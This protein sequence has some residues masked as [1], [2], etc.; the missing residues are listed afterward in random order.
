MPCNCPTL[1]G[2]IFSRWENSPIELPIQRSNDSARALHDARIAMMT[3]TTTIR[4]R[5]ARRSFSHVLALTLM[6]AMTLAAA[7]SA[8]AAVSDGAC[9]YLYEYE[10]DDGAS[11][12]CKQY[13]T[14]DSC[15]DQEPTTADPVLKCLWTG[16]ACNPSSASK[17]TARNAALGTENNNSGTVALYKLHNSCATS[18]KTGDACEALEW[19]VDG[20]ELLESSPACQVDFEKFFKERC[21]SS[22]TYTANDTTVNAKAT[23]EGISSDVTDSMITKL[24]DALLKS[25]VGETAD[26]PTPTVTYSV[27]GKQRF[28]GRID[29]ADFKT[30]V[31]TALSVAETAISNIEQTLAPSGRRLLQTTIN[32]VLYDVAATDMSSANSLRASTTTPVTCN[33][34]SGGTTVASSASGSIN[35]KMSID[36]V[37][38]STQAASIESA[39]EDSSFAGN[40]AY[41]ASAEGVSGLTVTGNEAAPAPP[42]STGSPGA[43]STSG[44]DAFKTGAIAVM[45]AT[46]IALLL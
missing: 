14:A 3:T 18:R 16:G 4:A 35:V 41:A 31:A 32:T 28:S 23:F 5:F 21:G 6:G 9:P 39:I 25:T 8:M 46:T 15:E 24:R 11:P 26:A 1:R 33:A 20:E 29:E 38:D 30:K 2:E 12:T 42:P 13:T 40:L 37:V 36:L 10:R 19:C 27:T 45:A 34:E 22:T 7:P 44:P 17:I 43:S